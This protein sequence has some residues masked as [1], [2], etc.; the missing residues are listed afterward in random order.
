MKNISKLLVSIGLLVT[1]GCTDLNVDIT[2]QYTE[3][4]SSEIALEAKMAN[5]YYAFRGPLGRRYSEACG[6]SS[7]EFIGISFDGDYYDNGTTAHPT[8]TGSIR[9]LPALTGMEI[10][11]EVSQAVI[12]P[13]LTLVAKTNPCLLPQ[14]RCVLSIISS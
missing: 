9:T 11:Q 14:S 5:V 10:S 1:T 12:K 4:P 3:Y 8:Y 13:S 7:D 6:C 2:S